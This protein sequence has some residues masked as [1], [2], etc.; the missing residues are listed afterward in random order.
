MLV[1][2]LGGFVSIH[3]RLCLRSLA[4]IV[5][6]SFLCVHS[7]AI[8]GAQTTG[9][10]ASDAS[11]SRKGADTCLACHDDQLSLA[12]FR[13]K[14]A[15]PSDGRSPF[16]HGQLQCES[17]HG[18]GG[19]HS[20]RLRRGEERPPVISFAPDDETSISAQNSMCLNCHESGV[21]FGWHSGPHN[22]DEIACADCHVSHAPRDPVLQTSTQP[23]VCFGCHQLQR[24][25][26]LKAFSHPVFEGKMDCNGC[27]SS[28][29]NTVAT[30]LARQTLNET[31]YECHA[32]KRGPF[33]W[34]HAPV[35]EDCGLCH[36]PHGSNHPGM[37]T[38]R[39][40]LLCQGCHSQSGHPSV[41]Y[42]DDGLV[43]GTPSR[44]LLGESCLNCHSQ[45]HGSNHPSGSKL[46]R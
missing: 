25:E 11:F 4:R 8:V 33:L 9:E 5:F 37:L 13:T 19:A 28:H 41:A 39:A 18:P 35:S 32:E 3:L 6:V 2:R 15:V 29:G 34:E 1:D 46:L 45:T 23:E 30:T 10:A 26:T 38:R 14:H 31:C 12:I 40:P 22:V 44:F 27:H 7:P 42:Q 16:G 21:G 24:S 17:C 36:S 43:G 20:P